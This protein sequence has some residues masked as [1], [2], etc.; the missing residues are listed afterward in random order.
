M[1]KEILEHIEAYLNGE[2]DRSELDKR[3][4][5]LSEEAIDEKIEWFRNSRTAIET[6][7]LREQLQQV[8]SDS[9]QSETKSATIRS[10]R[11]KWAVAASILIVA[12]AYIGI[13][14]LRE[15][16]LYA[17]YEYVDPGLPVLMSQSKD[18]LLYDAMTYYG[19]EN[20]EVTIDKLR[21]IQDQYPGN[22]TISFYLGASL[23]YSDR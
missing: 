15:P 1:K 12:I 14:Q 19:E 3:A 23:L 4:D 17:Q 20:Y 9:R 8:V 21:A 5:A 10:I 11:W 13:N 6:V 18:H 16:S 22:D 7:G 2:I